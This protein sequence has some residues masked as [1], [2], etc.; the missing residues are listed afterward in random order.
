MKTE[1]KSKLTYLL[2]VITF[3][4]MVVTGLIF[5]A[6][7]VYATDGS[8]F[9]GVLVSGPSSG[10]SIEYSNTSRN[11]AVTPDGTIYAVYHGTGGITVAKSTNDGE[12]FEDGVQV[13]SSNYQAEIAVSSSGTVY[14]G[15]VEGGTAKISKSVDAGNTFFSPKAVGTASSSIHM[16]VD[17]NYL[18]IIDKSGAYFYKSSD[19]GENFSSYDFHESYVFSD[20]HVDTSTGNVLVQKDNPTIIYYI[21]N[22]HGESFNGPYSPLGASVYYSVGSFSAG[23]NGNYLLVAG[24]SGSQ[25]DTA[26]KI[27]VDTGESANITIG[28]CSSSQGRSLSSDTYGNIVTGY[29]DGSSVYYKVSHDLGENFTDELQ[30]AQTDSANA[31]INTTNGDIMFLYEISGQIYLKVYANQLTG[32]D[33]YVSNSNLYMD[34]E[35]GTTIVEITNTSDSP[36]TIRDIQVEGDFTADKTLVGERLD[37]G[38]TAQIPVTFVPTQ[39]GT[40]TGRLIISSESFSDDRVIVLTGNCTEII[41]KPNKPYMDQDIVQGGTD[42]EIVSAA[43]EEGETA[44]LAPS[45]TT[46]FTEGET[47]TKLTGD[48]SSNAISAPVNE[49]I[50]KLFIVDNAGNISDESDNSVVVD[51]TKPEVTNIVLNPET[52]TNGDVEVTPNIIEETGITVAKYVY[53]I[54]SAS[55]GVEFTNHF[56]VTQNGQYTIYIEDLAENS[57]DRTFSVD[58]IDKTVPDIFDFNI[59]GGDTYTTMQTVSLA[60]YAEDN[61]SGIEWILVSDDEDFSD[62]NWQTVTGSVYDTTSY[63]VDWELGNEDGTKSVYIKLKDLAGNITPVFADGIILDRTESL[64][65]IIINN[66]E[67]Y[68]DSK[69][70]ELTLNAS[71]DTEFMRFSEDAEAW[72]AWEEFSESKTYMLNEPDGMK[73]I[74][75]QFMDSAGNISSERVYDEIELDTNHR[76]RI[77]PVILLKG[78]DTITLEE[79]ELFVE[80]GY[81]AFDNIDGDLTQWVRRTGYLNTNEVGIYVLT[82]KVVDSANNEASVT[83]IVEVEKKALDADSIISADDGEEI[84]DGKIEGAIEN[85]K[86]KNSAN[87][88]IKINESVTTENDVTVSFG[89]EQ[90]E[91]AKQNGVGVVFET[92]NTSI[93]IPLSTLDTTNMSTNSSLELV[94]ERVDTERDENIEMVNAI[95]E[96]N[97]NLVIYDNQI[98][99]FKMKIIQKD[100]EGNVTSEDEIDSFNSEE[101]IKLKMVVGQIG[102]ETVIM[103]F[104]YNPE[105]GKWEYVRGQYIPSEESVEILT[106]H[107]SIYSAMTLTVEQKRQELTNLINDPNITLEEVLYVIEDEDF[108]LDEIDRYLAFDQERKNETGQKIIDGKEDRNGNVYADYDDIK[109]EFNNI[110]SGI[111][112]GLIN[113]SI[114]PEIVLHGIERMRI[115]RGVTYIEPGVSASDNIEGDITGRVIVTGEVNTMRTGTYVLEYYVADI[116]GNETTVYRYVNVYTPEED[117]DHETNES[118]NTETEDE[119]EADMDG[120]TIYGDDTGDIEIIAVDVKN[121]SALSETGNRMVSRIYDLAGDGQNAEFGVIIEYNPD[122]VSNEEMLGLY[123]YDEEQKDW[124]YS[125]GSIDTENNTI[126][127]DLHSCGKIA[128]FEAEAQVAN[129][130]GHWAEQVVN[131]LAAR[132][133]IDLGDKKE[134]DS[135]GGVSRAQFAFYTSRLLGIEPYGENSGFIDVEPEMWYSGYISALRAEGIITGVSDIEFEPD[136]V[137]SREEMTIIMVRAYKYMKDSDMAATKNST[138]FTDDGKIGI[139]ARAGVYT[140]R[141]LGIVKGRGKNLFVPKTGATGAEMA[142][143]LYNFLQV[144]KIIY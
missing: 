50:Y 22:D 138:K 113:D 130:D 92:N 105:T 122:E 114:P 98:Y 13:C 109:G 28:S 58:N 4:L 36:I 8:R 56:T 67:N 49:G 60:V 132:N 2:G 80:K 144:T 1:K 75:V 115:R 104:Y 134:F 26:V 102:S 70:V 79:G 96:V 100:D 6:E 83:R 94:C 117:E 101:D 128:V 14:V 7:D 91:N 71:S 57:K 99:D 19:N 34:D 48:G 62:A 86:R 143:I 23:D 141:S 84:E 121:V 27:D 16:A 116:A 32:Y 81:T 124:V 66:D 54:G 38:Q 103:T 76:D 135:D 108:G 39:V 73:R 63:V 107:L 82:Y 139:W 88:K 85:A 52:W 41:V 30:V 112:N 40:S 43:P 127:S 45:G 59:N 106:R 123:Y 131:V 10:Y 119:P 77:P 95:K 12:S 55:Q 47:M 72:T 65:T 15:W 64:G 37:Q 31:A 20:V 89:M 118:L 87:I 136:R 46:I 97:E 129:M 126:T 18:Y 125:G 5:Y 68:T 42:I 93:V 74:Y 69:E 111:Y 21:S 78:D 142:Q 61:L 137:I 110:V 133:I 120:I 51:N 17:G 35:S 90:V 11:L 25:G 24:G 33:L 140:A 53:G 29:N 44:W 3:A 9:G